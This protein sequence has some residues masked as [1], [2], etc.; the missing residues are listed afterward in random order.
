MRYLLFFCL[1][2]FCSVLL[3]QERMENEAQKSPKEQ[4]RLTEKEVKR[5]LTQLDSDF[6]Y[7]R[8]KAA[9]SIRETGVEGILVVA[10]VWKESDLSSRARGE[11]T[12]L[13]I[14][15]ETKEA[16]SLLV[17]MALTE[18][19]ETLLQQ[20]IKGVI[21]YAQK[22]RDEAALGALKRL[23]E[24]LTK[25]KGSEWLEATFKSA[26]KQ[27]ILT[28]FKWMRENG[29]LG[30]SYPGQYSRISEYGRYAIEA[31]IDLVK[32][33]GSESANAL[34]ALLDIVPDSRLYADRI[35]ELYRQK[36]F[37][38]TLEVEA[39]LYLMGRKDYFKKRITL[40]EKQMD[41]DTSSFYAKTRGLLR[42]YRLIRRYDRCEELQKRIIQRG[43]TSS[44][45]MYYNLA[46]Y[47]AMQKKIDEALDS[48]EKA[49]QNGFRNYE[50]MKIDKEIDSIRNAERFK[51]L[52][53]EHFN[54]EDDQ[55][56]GE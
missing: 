9:R 24:S 30:G 1:L 41:T 5:L 47:Q 6:Y 14:E 48:I 28:T 33:G 53:K 26:Y 40:L 45:V 49:F 37:P 31:L 15:M 11:L 13:L 23:V 36:E 27:L 39:L 35:E 20:Q 55:E 32:E 12:R 22:H 3:S 16:S 25:R 34:N 51:R 54:I 56:R 19:Q 46:C 4:R 38:Q 52:L 50:W 17:E 42:A 10:K 2:P 7:D 44:G 43:G 8:K 21:M 18:T 29:M